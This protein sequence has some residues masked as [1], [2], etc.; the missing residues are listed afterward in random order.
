MNPLR[1]RPAPRQV[2]ADVD[3][4]DDNGRPALSAHTLRHTFGTYL[5]RSGVDVV[6]V[7][8]LMG[9]KRLETT[10]RYTL[11]TQADMEAAVA[12]LPTDE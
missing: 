10:R 2:A 3:L 8:Q 6:T 4:V 11:R 9:H 12:R 7:A 5:T 1:S